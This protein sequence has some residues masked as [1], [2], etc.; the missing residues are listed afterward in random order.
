MKDEDTKDLREYKRYPAP[1]GVY[2]NFC[3]G[4]ENTTGFLIDLSTD[5]ASFEYLQDEDRFPEPNRIDIAYKKKS[6]RIINIPCKIVFEIDANNAQPEP[7]N[8]K[9]IGIQFGALSNQQKSD[10][11]LLIH[12]YWGY[13]APAKKSMPAFLEKKHSEA[14]MRN[15]DIFLS[16]LKLLVIG[17]KAYLKGYPMGAYR[18]EAMSRNAA[19][20]TRQVGQQAI[21][22]FG[23]S[24]S[25]ELKDQI[26]MLSTLFQKIPINTNMIKDIESSLD[27]ICDELSVNLTQMEFLRVA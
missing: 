8:W 12:Q 27:C 1:E 3:V 17:A 22:E 7:V 19:E 11:T 24:H 14:E 16:R 2:V 26:L 6:L 25:P 18:K 23:K 20:I 13:P 4:G 9:K 10:I 21:L 15:D 5:G